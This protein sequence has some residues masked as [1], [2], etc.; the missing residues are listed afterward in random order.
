MIPK[1]LLAVSLACLA[2]FAAAAEDA[3]PAKNPPKLKAGVFMSP[4][5]VMER[6]WGGYT[7]MAVELWEDVTDELNLHNEYV[8]YHNLPDLL[9][10]TADGKLDVAVLDLSA[11]HERAET[12]KFS[13]P[14]YDSGLRIMINREAGSSLWA[15][16]SKYR[17]FRVYALLMFVFL[18]LTFVL[19][20]MRRKHDPEF[21]DDIREGLSSSFLNIVESALDGKMEQRHLGWAGNIFFIGWLL[22]GMAA[23][24]YVTSTMTSSMTSAHLTGDIRQPADLSGKRVAVLKGSVG[25]D[26]FTDMGQPAVTFPELADAVDALLRQ[27]VDAVV[28]DAPLLE[29]HV[30]ENPDLPLAVVGDLFQPDKYCFAAGYRN[31]E[32]MDKA[33]VEIIRLRENK[34]I[35]ELKDKYFSGDNNEEELAWPGEG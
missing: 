8:L 1:A 27:E 3:R 22:F 12:L 17:H 26:F 25:E 31:A 10:D 4:P 30:H 35:A 15:A 16:L 21:T 14:W 32:L 19:Y 33:S 34:R 13:H 7:G 18:V 2:A 11:T 5:F 28:T 20:K 9:N 6:D 24:A 29:Y 23:V